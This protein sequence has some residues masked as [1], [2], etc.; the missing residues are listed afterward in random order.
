MAEAGGDW[1]AFL[2]DDARPLPG[3]VRRLVTLAATCEFDGVA[4]V[5]LPWYAEG[6]ERWFRDEYA[7]NAAAIKAYG[8][9]PPGRFAS[10]GNCMFRRCVLK[11]VGGFPESLGPAG[12]RFSYGEDTQPQVRMLRR[13]YRLGG[14]PE[15]RVEHL[16]SRRKQDL[17]WLLRRARDQGRDAWRIL[18][19]EPRLLDLALLMYRLGS[20]PLR[21][22]YGLL[23]S[24]WRPKGWRNWVIACLGPIIATWAELGSGLRLRLGRG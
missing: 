18:D 12:D 1:I 13:G 10:G 24:P 3:Y 16:V 4:G 6:R 15:L 11:A 21:G 20:R 9:L 2:D 8:E 14:D 7:S 22:L 23:R 17:A 19:R 5:Y